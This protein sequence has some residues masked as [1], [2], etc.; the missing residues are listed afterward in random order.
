MHYT[1]QQ[2]VAFV[3]ADNRKTLAGVGVEGDFAGKKIKISSPSKLDQALDE[4]IQQQVMGL[5]E[6]GKTVVIVLED[7]ELTGLIALRDRLRD[8]AK[9]A[10]KDL[11]DLGISGVMLTGIIPVPRRP[12]LPS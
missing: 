10:L 2:G 4:S 9:A 8:D 6:E 7:G 5:E 12:L 1:E 3:H 11:A